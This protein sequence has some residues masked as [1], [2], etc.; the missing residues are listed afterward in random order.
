MRR[1]FLL[2]VVF[3]LV[4]C[5]TKREDKVEI[6]LLNKRIVSSEG[7]PFRETSLYKKL[8][9]SL[10]D[11]ERYKDVSF[12]PVDSTMIYGGKFEVVEA[13]LLE[14]P[15]ITDDQIV[16]LN[17]KT[18]EIIFSNSGMKRLG[19]VPPNG[20][21]GAPFAICVNK[22]P[23]LTGYF[24][25]FFY[26]RFLFS[27]NRISYFPNFKVK[28]ISESYYEEGYVITRNHGNVQYD[29]YLPDLNEYPELVKAFR[30]SD[31]IIE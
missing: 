10:F 6:Y 28:D 24:E 23:V 5:E 4:S 8:P 21:L 20:N 13:D 17:L 29:P 25:S 1:F 18:N 3:T 31:R 2:M 22:K 27:W 15:Q 16:G 30:D 19:D 11:L 12:D 9:D 7:I 14:K 26:N